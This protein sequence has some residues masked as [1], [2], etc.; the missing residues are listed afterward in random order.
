MLS[1]MTVSLITQQKH[2]T[3]VLG[4]KVPPYMTDYTLTC[5]CYAFLICCF[6]AAKFLSENFTK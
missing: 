6:A 3:K 5:C 2:T 4:K 1:L